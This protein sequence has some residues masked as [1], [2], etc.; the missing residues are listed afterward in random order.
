[1]TANQNKS[2][3]P[4]EVEINRLLLEMKNFKGSEQDYSNMMKNLEILTKAL[5]NTKAHT[6]KMD[7]V[8]LV[9]GNLA[10]ILLILGYEN[11]HVVTSKA[12]GFVLK[13]KV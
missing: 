1:M 13:T 3:N 4:F 8:L 9:A 12:L 11:V 6:L 10:G 2:Q 5:V 7:T